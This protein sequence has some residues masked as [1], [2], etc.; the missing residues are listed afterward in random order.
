[1]QILS[2][3]LELIKMNTGIFGNNFFF[4]RFVFGLYVHST[5]TNMKCL[6]SS[7]AAGFTALYFCLMKVDASWA[8]GH[9]GLKLPTT[10]NLVS[11]L[12]FTLVR[13]ESLNYY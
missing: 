11:Y 8:G 4:F 12:N 3:Y 7:Q 6:P 5:V 2:K 10:D 13:L 9:I 1:M